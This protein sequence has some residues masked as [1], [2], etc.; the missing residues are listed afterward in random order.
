MKKHL[1]DVQVKQVKKYL[2]IKNRTIS[3]HKLSRTEYKKLRTRSPKTT[4]KLT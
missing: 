4:A 3:I 1:F 2:F